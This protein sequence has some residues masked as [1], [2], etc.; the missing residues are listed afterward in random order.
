MVLA[1]IYFKHTALLPTVNI[2]VSCSGQDWPKPAIQNYIQIANVAGWIVLEY[3]LILH[4]IKY[5]HQ[6][7][8]F[9]TSA[10]VELHIEP[11][12]VISTWISA[13]QIMVCTDH[14]TKSF[15][16]GSIQCSSIR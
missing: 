10:P 4:N 14:S 16:K 2:S 15:W 1:L 12:D 7:T 3:Y 13:G 5:A 11:S 6:C 8:G 9:L